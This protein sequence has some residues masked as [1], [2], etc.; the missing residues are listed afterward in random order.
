LATI[1][2]EKL[3]NEGK[4]LHLNNQIKEADNRNTELHNTMRE[5]DARHK[6]EL[7][8]CQKENAREKNVIIASRHKEV[9]DSALETIEEEEEEPKDD[10]LQ[11]EINAQ[12][13]KLEEERKKNTLLEETIRNMRKK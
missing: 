5:L 2:L 11:A 9:L 6:N 1:K 10:G 8:D 4:I 13:N 12:F 7:S 3:E